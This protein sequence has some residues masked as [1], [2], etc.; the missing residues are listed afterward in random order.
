M[1]RPV[2]VAVFASGSGS[3]FQALL[4]AEREGGASWE[5]VLLLSDRASAGALERA[6]AAGVATGIV[7]F[8]QR[9]MDDV[10]A[11]MQEILA[12]AGVEAI[13]L[14]GFLRLIPPGVVQRWRGRIVNIHPGLLPAF[15]GKGMWGLNVHRAVLEAGARITGPTVHLVDEIYDRGRILAQWPVPVLAGDTAESLAARVLAVE[16]R[17]YPRVAEHVCRAV[18]EDREVTALDIGAEAFLPAD[19]PPDP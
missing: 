9:D 15:G 12:D 11:E 16:H 17:L 4:D 2:R 14:A 7:S 5:T 6:E 1:S 10:D 3:N 8:R 19:A 13:F 18:R